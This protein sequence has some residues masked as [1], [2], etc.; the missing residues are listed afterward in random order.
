MIPLEDFFRNPE[1]SNYQISPDS[2]SISFTKPYKKRRNI[3][4]AAGGFDDPKR[5]TSVTDRD[6]TMYFWKGNR[7]IVFLKDS[8]GDENYHLFSVDVKSRVQKDLTPFPGAKAIIIDSLPDNDTDIIIGLNKRDPELFDAYK[9]DVDAGS[10][11]LLAENPGNVARWVT[12]HDGKIRAGIVNEGINRKLIF[13]DDENSEFKEILKFSFKDTLEP[14]IFTFDNREL[15][16]LSNIGRDKAAI[17]KFD[18]RKAEEALVFERPDVD[19]GGLSYS[20]KRKVLLAFYYITW[21][22][23][24]NIVDKEVEDIF[25]YLSKKLPDSEIYIS[26]MDRNEENFIVYTMSDRSAG[27]YYLFDSRG[28]RLVKLASVFPWLKKEDL[29]KVLPIEY[30]TRDGLTIHG[31]LTLPKGKE[32]KNLPVVVNPH[33]GPWARDVW[34]FDPETQFLASRGYA[35]LQMNF[36]GSTGYGKNFYEASFK[37]W[38]KK[39]QDDITD[40][41]HWLIGR[42]IADPGR[43]AIYGGSYGGYAVLAGLSFTPEI[44]ACGIDYVGVSNIF[45]LFKSIPPY[46]KLELEEF[47]EKV[48]HPETDEALLKEISPVFHADRIKAP[49]FV[50]QGARDPRVNINESNQIVEALRKRGVKVQYMVKEN[51]GHGFLSEENRLDFYR[52]MEKFL[53]NCLK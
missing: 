19:A 33:G 48:G 1:S 30:K 10:L 11:T 28:K 42:G 47:Y 16:C 25:S 9:I 4:V 46:W 12:D 3:F 18:P 5:I 40:A 13:R 26:D 51:E 43:I 49:L 52:Q 50:A 20:R 44:Y 41:V 36:R 35:V 45:T 23:E 31:Y 34:T 8:G 32:P 17:V 37:Q 24:R 6:I 21:K 38:G 53:K 2:R 22:L 14:L 27:E 15:Y 29:A 7:H 39:M